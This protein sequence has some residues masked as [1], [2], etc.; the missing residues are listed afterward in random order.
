MTPGWPRSRAGAAAALLAAALL[1]Y[2]NA[3]PGPFQFDD[4]WALV[5]APATAGLAGW[6]GSLPGI[7][8]LLKLTF[9]LNAALAPAPWAYRAVNLGVHLANILLAWQ[10]LRL[11]LPV[12]APG[13]ARPELAAFGA[14]LLFALHPAATE[15]VTYISGRSISLM[16]LPYLAALCLLARTPRPG[17]G[18]QLALAALFAAALAV[19]ETAVTLPIAAAGLMAWRGDPPRAIARGLAGLGAVLAIGALLAWMTPGYHSFFGWSLQTRGPGAQ[20]LGQLEAHAYL[21][22]HPL[23]ALKTNI[24]PDLGVPAALGLRHVALLAGALG[25]AVLA[26][27]QRR[28]RP[29]LGAGL[30]WYLLHLLPSNSLLPRFDLANDRHLYLSLLGPALLA[31]VPLAGLRRPAL[32]GGGLLALALVLA[33]ATVARN[34]DY[35]SELALWQATVRDSPGKARA[36]TNLGFARQQA[37][38]LAGARAA[39]ACALQQ[40]PDYRQA[41]WN[42]ATLGPAPPDAACPTGKPGIVPTPGPTP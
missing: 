30:A 19:R 2:A 42:L 28:L 32:A 10:V 1:A 3:L 34:Q 16:A 37:G 39:Y 24:D 22:T 18:V 15:A 23:L 41:A 25:L 9:A 21:L 33:T 40:D 26:W 17:T 14:A 7:R 13:H 20:L 4:W 8:P 31:A 29:W 11:L 27:H 6:W 12:L 5:D 36:W 35:R 38:D